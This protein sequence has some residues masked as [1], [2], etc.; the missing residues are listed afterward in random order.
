MNTYNNQPP[1]DQEI[2]YSVTELNNEIS[3]FLDK[4]YGYIYVEGEISN[5]ARP[6]SGHLYFSLKD[7]NAQVK[8]A[9][10]RNALNKINNIDIKNGSKVILKA[11]V[12]LYAPRGD[13]QL[14]VYDLFE[15]GFGQLQKEFLELKNKLEKQGFFELAN[16]KAFPKL[17]K[18]AAII[19]SS[20]G[21]AIKD[22]LTTIKRR[23][24]LL[25]VIIIPTVVQGESS[26]VSITNAINQVNQY[27]INNLNI[28]DCIILSRGGG[29]IEDLWGFNAESVAQA[30]YNS[31]IPIVTGIGHEIDFTIADFVA[32]HRAA[33]PTAAA[34]FI[35]PN[36]IE[37]LNL[38][39]QKQLKLNKNISYYLKNNSKK[40]EHI[41][42]RLNIQNPIN[43]LNNQIQKLDHITSKLIINIEKYLNNLNNKIQNLN[44]QLKILNPEKNLNNNKSKLEKLSNKLSQIIKVLLTNKQHE[45]KLL[46]QNLDNISPLKILSRGYSITKNIDGKNIKSISQLNTND[47]I[48]TILTDG[49]IISIVCEIVRGQR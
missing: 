17:P 24:P 3:L 13:Y 12:S 23:W 15:S 40:L 9:L 8:C 39:F 10:F 7:K 45:I 28:I 47:K 18:T 19:T 48:E 16:K 5:L 32:D 22:I 49:N 14:I 37:Y 6:I 44:Y 2:C 42:H 20:T 36:K 38:I 11:K 31:N 33:T 43:K 1:I 34:E 27:S 29:S 21:A 41:K 26:S 25:N 30:I 4:T 35:T 46:A